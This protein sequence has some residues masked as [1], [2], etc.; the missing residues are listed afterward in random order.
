M[1]FRPY[2]EQE[3]EQTVFQTKQEKEMVL[4]S[5]LCTQITERNVPTVQ[6]FTYSEISHKQNVSVMKIRLYQ[7]TFTILRIWYAKYPNFKYQYETE[8][9]RN[10]EKFVP[11]CSITAQSV[12]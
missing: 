1:C 5:I 6:P 2:T 11:C 9:A 10:R 8:P 7:K 4:Q 12:L 3:T